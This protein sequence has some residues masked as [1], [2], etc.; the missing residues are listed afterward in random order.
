MTTNPPSAQHQR[1]PG[2]GR[3]RRRVVWAGVVLAVLAVFDLAR[4][5]DPWPAPLTA[6]PLLVVAVAVA[7][8]VTPAGSR[9]STVLRVAAGV[10]SLGVTAV[11]LAV[12]ETT[13]SV[14]LAE[15]GVLLV[16]V[17]VGARA[18]DGLRAA[19][20]A[21]VA[22]GA[23]VAVALRTSTSSADRS[24]SAL[25]LLVVALLLA[26][27]GGSAG[28]TVRRRDAAVA[29]SLHAERLVLAADLHDLVAHHVTAV[30]LQ[31]RMAQVLIDDDP[32]AAREVLRGVES[33]AQRALDS[34]RTVVGV[35]RAPGE[36]RGPAQARGLAPGAAGD[37]DAGG[38]APAPVLADLQA[39]VDR[40]AQVGPPARLDM[41][42]AALAEV[43]DA[44]QT[45]VVAVVREAL[46]N[47][48]K[49]GEQVS[50]VV[51][52]VQRSGPGVRAT[53]TDD[54]RADPDAAVAGTG[55]GLLGMAE[56]VA[57]IGGALV[58]GPRTDG[59]GWRVEATLGQTGAVQARRG[60]R[61]ELS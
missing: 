3:V 38:R 42:L 54:G 60:G 4:L 33:D 12:P 5:D 9:R 21:V 59:P 15:V 37:A 50:E 27:L 34:M 16:L 1:G 61:Q 39:L 56:R 29:A 24:S 44:A 22:C 53:V 11:F 46:T 7:G 57:A 43:P 20:P 18:T 47:T 31:T 35:L 30:V 41:D 25:L 14:S 17:V 32:A 10:L 40:Y 6:L 19:V 26:A 51:V 58:A 13:G 55:F 36:G 28:L 2:A 23:V 49:H 45:T 48:R 52:A 8:L